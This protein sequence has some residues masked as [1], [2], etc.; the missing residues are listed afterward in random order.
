[1]PPTA[2]RARLGALARRLDEAR[3]AADRMDA[4]L[5]ELNRAAAAMLLGEPTRRGG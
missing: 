3:A 5:A 4:Q 2:E 1:V